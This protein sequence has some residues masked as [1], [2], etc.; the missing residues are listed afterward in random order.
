MKEPTDF[1]ILMRARFLQ[2]AELPPEL[3]MPMVA[4]FDRLVEGDHERA[5][6]LALSIAG[7]CRHRAEQSAAAR[8]TTIESG[9]A[10]RA[11]LRP[12]ACEELANRN[13]SHRE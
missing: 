12:L 2:C 1:E 6:N 4:L 13:P 9:K 3:Q 7:T 10:G 5:G 8:R 11:A